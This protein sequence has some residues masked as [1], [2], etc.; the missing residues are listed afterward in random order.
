MKNTKT[1]FILTITVL[2]SLFS[3][4]IEETVDPN[5]PSADGVLKNATI[6][7]LNEL[8]TGILA[9]TSSGLGV[10]YEVAGVVGRD[11]YRFD[12]ADPR[13]VGDLMGTGNLDNSAFYTNTSYA[14]RYA[15][16]KTANILI[17][18]CQNTPVLTAEQVEGYLGFANTLKAFEL[19]NVLNQQYDNG[20]R[21]EVADP[22]NLGP[23]TANAAEALAQIAT[24]FSEAAVHNA[25]AGNSF[26]FDLTSGFE[27]EADA[28]SFTIPANFGKFI[29]ALQAR[30]ELYRG[31]FA[32]ALTFVNQ[33]FIDE[34]GNFNLGVYRVFANASGDRVNPLFFPQNTNGTTRLAHPTWLTDAIPGDLRLSKATIRNEVAETADLVATHDAFRYTSNTSPIAIIRNE[35]LLLIKA[36]ALIQTNQFADAKTIIDLIRVDVGGI[37]VYTGPLA[38][39]EMI[40]ELLFQRRYSLWD[41][42]HRWIDMR[43]YNRLD[44]LTI[45][46]PG[47][48]VIP[49]LPRPFNEI[50]VQG[51]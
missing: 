17:E 29:K 46:R 49:Q 30:V 37:G 20:I 3:C 6:G 1:Y 42:G 26:A 24:I 12:T 11:V 31:N 18:A 25:A 14:Q 9:S 16:I 23:F 32:Q 5:Q 39:P 51:G 43:R 15:T 19:L 27:T 48:S 10:Y 4:E 35:E 2:L 34:S 44:E 21:I 47:D 36:E 13:Y 22:L 33:S 8:V 40:D 38:S 41:E 7:Q 28:D 50:G 45:D